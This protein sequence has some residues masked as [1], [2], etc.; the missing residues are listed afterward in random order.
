MAKTQTANRRA[1]PFGEGHRPPP[2]GS[3]ANLRWRGPVERSRACH[4][5]RNWGLSWAGFAMVS[6]MVPAIGVQAQPGV[7]GA[8]G[9]T[10]ATASTADDQQGRMIGTIVRIDG[11]DLVLDLGAGAVTVGD[12]LEVRRAITVLHP[13]T[14]QRL[15][16]RFVIGRVQV[17]Q[18]GSSLSLA[19]LVAAPERPLSVG[20]GLG[21]AGDL[22]D[23]D[24]ANEPN[25][26]TAIAEDSS[27]GGRREGGDG[28]PRAVVAANP[29]SQSSARAPRDPVGATASSPRVSDD[30]VEVLAVFRATLGHPPAERIRYYETFIR[31]HPQSIYAALLQ[32]ELA[33]LRDIERSI[34]GSRRSVAPIGGPG[35]RAADGSSTAEAL[36]VEATPLTRVNSGRP[37]TIAVRVRRAAPIRTL[38]LYARAGGGEAYAAVP[39]PIDARGHASATVPAAVVTPPAFE[40]FIEAS[41]ASGDGHGGAAAGGDGVGRAVDRSD[42]GATSGA[43]VGAV[44]SSAAPRRVEVDPVDGGEGWPVGRSRI[45]LTS[46]VVSFNGTEGNDWFWLNEADFLYRLH[47]PAIEAARIGYGHMS[48]QGGL[49]ADLDERGLSARPVGFTY[50]YLESE[51][52]IGDLFALIPRGTVGLGRTRYDGQ[53][54]LRAGLELRAR[55]GRER[56]T[57]LIL[58][59]A[60]IPEVGQ[61]AFLG[62]AWQPAEGWPMKAEVHVTDQPVNS[63][64]LAVRGVLEV[65]RDLT[66]QIAIALRAS[67]QG[68]TIDHA[69]FGA[70]AAATFDW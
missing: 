27:R 33:A 32:Q 40:Y 36:L 60:T 24:G 15:R 12:R 35:F 10:S 34:T 8:A 49:I 25:P 65:G 39:M 22:S 11:E 23:R 47:L 53:D 57:H 28:S 61:R 21:V 29:S 56:S 64:E 59:A 37:V 9:G 51:F 44:A 52:R 18:V 14:R 70:G 19:R 55:I 42:R 58:A 20:D 68:R 38:T 45:R 16:D 50:G 4:W 67:Y 69:G 2:A 13:I 30:A 54:G 7:E 17:Y 41:I 31:R 66:D 26:G 6:A 3:P 5:A 62:L 63:D 46:E 1:V 43:Q 48:G